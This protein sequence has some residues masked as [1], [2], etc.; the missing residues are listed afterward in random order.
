[1]NQILIILAA[2]LFGF[3]TAG[4]RYFHEEGFSLYE[5]ALLVIFVPVFLAPLLVF[6]SR[7]RPRLRLFPF[8]VTFGFIG[9]LLQLAQFAG[10][11]LGLPVA[12]VVLLLYTQPLWTTLLGRL[13]LEERITRAKLGA[14][15]LAFSGIVVLVDPGRPQE[16]PVAGLLAAV[17]AGFLLSLWVIWSRKSALKEQHFVVTTFGFTLFCSLWLLL[18]YPMVLLLPLDV[19]LVRLEFGLYRNYWGMVT[20]YTVLA[21]IV[22]SFLVFYALKGVEASTAGVLLLFEPVSAAVMA[23]FWFQEALASNVWVG[24]ALILAAN[25]IVIRAAPRL[26]APNGPSGP[27]L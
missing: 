27:S 2:C 10:I 24:G 16:Y 5:I 7:F 11:A 4:G 17:L 12:L 13:V 18:L 15:L 21:G 3:V 14:A 1:V 26:E 19:S 9:A 6:R 22:P 8:F 20:L 23:Y 25:V